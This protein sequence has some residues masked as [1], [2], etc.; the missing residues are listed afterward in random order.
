MGVSKTANMVFFRHVKYLGKI[1]P[2]HM[3]KVVEVLTAEGVVSFK[4]LDFQ[5]LQRVIVGRGMLVIICDPW[6]M[7]VFGAHKK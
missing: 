4:L 6:K 1:F 5:I 3:S 2:L 7:P